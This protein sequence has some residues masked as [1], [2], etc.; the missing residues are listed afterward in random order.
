[1]FEFRLIELL[2]TDDGRFDRFEEERAAFLLDMERERS[3]LRPRI[4]RALVRLGARIDPAA[5]SRNDRIS[6]PAA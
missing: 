2:P 5:T 6:Q 3:G 1:M 4:A